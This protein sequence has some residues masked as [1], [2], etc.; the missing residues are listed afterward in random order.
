MDQ[1]AGLKEIKMYSDY[2]SPYAWM[3]FDQVFRLK[4]KY[5]IRV[6]WMP[7][8]LRLKGQ[9]QRSQYSEFKIKYSY[10][11]VRRL[12]RENGY[13]IR[14]PLKIYDTKPALIGGLFA[15]KHGKLVEYSGEAYRRFFLREFEADQPEAVCKLLDELQLSSDEYRTYL[16]GEGEKDYQEAQEQAMADQIFGVPICVFEGE[17][18]WGQDRLWLLEKRLQQAGLAGQI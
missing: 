15:E 9:G 7:F 1:S 5:K 12:G 14:G 4:E 18:F 8:Q 16:S 17:P 10:M 3:A 13:Y 2:K 6:K 11:D